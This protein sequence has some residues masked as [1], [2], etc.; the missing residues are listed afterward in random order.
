MHHCDAS[1]LLLL[2]LPDYS[3]CTG[4]NCCSLAAEEEGC[5]WCHQHL[6]LCLTTCPATH[7]A[8]PASTH[9]A[10][11]ASSS[12]R[13]LTHARVQNTS[14]QNSS[15][16]LHLQQ[17]EC[18]AQGAT[19]CCTCYGDSGTVPHPSPCSCSLAVCACPLGCSGA[20]A[21][22]AVHLLMPLQ[23]TKRQ[24]WLLMPLRAHQL[25]TPSSCLCLPS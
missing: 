15:S 18:L 7:S 12:A 22:H 10:A 25:L 2:L 6:F 4:N 1:L 11:L 19:A 23:L 5:L 16:S 9:S 8:A 24:V 20:S 13:Y 14:L 21:A 17:H 3:N